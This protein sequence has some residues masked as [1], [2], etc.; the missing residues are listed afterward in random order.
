MSGRERVIMTVARFVISVVLVVC[1]PASRTAAVEPKDESRTSPEKGA[2][3]VA[4]ANAPRDEPTGPL[5][6]YWDEK[7]EGLTATPIPGARTVV[8]SLAD[9]QR[10]RRSDAGLKQV[11]RLEAA[12]GT[13]LDLGGRYQSVFVSLVD[14]TGRLRVVCLDA[15]PGEQALSAVTAGG[16]H[17]R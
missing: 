15:E 2:A 1:L 12:E 9:R 4:S 10:L 6:L 11:P 3:V 14:L 16:A 5:V 17:A 13:A 8:L 7:K